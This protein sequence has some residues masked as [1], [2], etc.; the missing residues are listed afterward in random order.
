MYC[1]GRP[2]MIKQGGP[3]DWEDGLRYLQVPGTGNLV[4]WLALD[5]VGWW[6]S[7]AGCRRDLRAVG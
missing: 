4:W 3:L 2:L 5:G 7:R 6:T 1:N